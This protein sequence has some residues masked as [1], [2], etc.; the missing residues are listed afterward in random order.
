MLE[1]TSLVVAVANDENLLGIHH[2]AYANCE[3]SLWHLV[4]IIVKETAVGNDSVG[5]K[6]L[7]ASARNQ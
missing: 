4:D 5:S 6:R 3:S 2:C 7:D 1:S